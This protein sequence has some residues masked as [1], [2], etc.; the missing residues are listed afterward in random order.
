VLS[1]TFSCWVCG[2]KSWNFLSRL[3]TT[4]SH[5]PR[6][7]HC[8]TFRDIG[9]RWRKHWYHESNLLREMTLFPFSTSGAL[10]PTRHTQS[11][12]KLYIMSLNNKIII[13]NFHASVKHIMHCITSS[14]PSASTCLVDS[15]YS[16]QNYNNIAVISLSSI[17][18]WLNYLSLLIIEVPGAIYIYLSKHIKNIY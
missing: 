4:I 12:I 16:E 8:D 18:P 7:S 17:L 6:D 2:L 1:P 13:L 9:T 11:Q 3:S 5:K 10:Q 14:P 15:N